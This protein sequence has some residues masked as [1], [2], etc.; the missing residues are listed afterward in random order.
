MNKYLKIIEKI[1]APKKKQE[2]QIINQIKV[3][4]FQFKTGNFW[5]TVLCFLMVL[6]LG[7]TSITSYTIYKVLE[8][9]KDP[10]IQALVRIHQIKINANSN[11]NS[12]PQNNQQKD[13]EPEKEVLEISQD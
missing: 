13:V 2:Q 8:L 1:M 12:T 7:V 3:G 4:R 5:L 11:V 9:Y 6:M 10:M